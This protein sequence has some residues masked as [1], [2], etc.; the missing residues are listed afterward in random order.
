[1]N[2]Q[3][4]LGNGEG[5]IAEGNTVTTKACNGRFNM[6]KVLGQVAGEE[7]EEKLLQR[8]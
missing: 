7:E 8:V 1:M 2:N 5:A 4:S 3:P 6:M